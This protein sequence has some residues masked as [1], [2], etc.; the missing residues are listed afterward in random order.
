MLI[1]RFMG[2]KRSNISDRMSA[3]EG[4]KFNYNE[5]ALEDNNEVLI[6]AIDKIGV[7]I[8]EVD[9]DTEG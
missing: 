6:Q 2:D 4:V 7:G 1:C 3:F 8:K 9:N 5:K